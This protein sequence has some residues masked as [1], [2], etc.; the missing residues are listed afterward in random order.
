MFPTVSAM[1]YHLE[2]GGCPSGKD[3][4]TVD[5]AVH[6]CNGKYDI[7][8]DDE[9]T[10]FS[11]T[12]CPQNFEFMSALL[13]HAEREHFQRFEPLA[14]FPIFEGFTASLGSFLDFLSEAV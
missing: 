10:P 11:C 2:S 6:N 3:A 4:I 1:V 14:D 5:D 12:E 9:R 13:R 7:L 8:S